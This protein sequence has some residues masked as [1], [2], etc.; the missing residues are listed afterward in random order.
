MVIS[1]LTEHDTKGR[2]IYNVMYQA[3]KV[4]KIAMQN[5]T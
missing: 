4:I 3:K 1:F 2:Y 5:V